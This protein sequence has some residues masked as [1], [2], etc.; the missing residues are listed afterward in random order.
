M[1]APGKTLESQTLVAAGS[2]RRNFR[3]S[4]SDAPIKAGNEMPVATGNLRRVSAV[5]AS[6][7]PIGAELTSRR[8]GRRLALSGSPALVASSTIGRYLSTAGRPPD[9]AISSMWF[10]GSYRPYRTA[11][12]A[13]LIDIKRWSFCAPCCA[14]TQ[15][16]APLAFTSISKRFLT[17]CIAP[18]AI[19]CSKDMLSNTL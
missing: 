6:D 3:N 8:G 16:G 11:S 15:L 7:T 1:S 12:Q 9:M 14:E 5:S 19:A 10:R 13:L 17:R 2:L 18:R 4:A